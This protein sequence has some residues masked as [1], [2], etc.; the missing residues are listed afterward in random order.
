MAFQQRGSPCSCSPCSQQRERESGSL[1]PRG[2]RNPKRKTLLMPANSHS[3]RRDRWMLK[4]RPVWPYFPAPSSEC[5]QFSE[6]KENFCVF[7]I[8]FIQGTWIWELRLHAREKKWCKLHKF[9]DAIGTWYLIAKEHVQT[10]RGRY[11]TRHLAQ[12]QTMQLFKKKIW[13]QT[14]VN[15]ANCLQNVTAGLLHI[16]DSISQAWGNVP[17]GQ[18][19]QLLLFLC[20]ENPDND[21]TYLQAAQFIEILP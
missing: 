10:R 14:D 17:S 21:V 1:S 2:L 7:T 5:L 19:K 4:S 13:C 20:I 12:G 11:W 15:R 3:E 16:P 18:R 6:H 8:P 9:C